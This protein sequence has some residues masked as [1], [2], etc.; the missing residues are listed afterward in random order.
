MCLK[1]PKRIGGWEGP[2][3]WIDER[4]A[5]GQARPSK[6]V[7]VNKKSGGMI[8]LQIAPFR[9][10][11]RI[12]ILNVRL[13]LGYKLPLSPAVEVI[14]LFLWNVQLSTDIRPKMTTHLLRTTSPTPSNRSG[15][16]TLTSRISALGAK[17]TR[18]LSGGDR[19]REEEVHVPV[20]IGLVRFGSVSLRLFNGEGV[21]EKTRRGG[22]EGRE[23][24][25]K[26]SPLRVRGTYLLSWRDKGLS[27]IDPARASAFSLLISGQSACS[28]L[29]PLSSLIS[30]YLFLSAL[31]CVGTAPLPPPPLPWVPPPTES[32]PCPPNLANPT[33]CLESGPPRAEPRAPRVTMDI[34]YGIIQAF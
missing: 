12:R 7:Q 14:R 11:I 9:I 17:L 32:Q 23:K 4:Q 31:F 34:N 30:S 15:T 3:L 27:D 5:G 8:A 26:I 2:G 25:G 29:P 22:K 16:P 24:E 6:Q 13:V 33:P 28:L 1:N 19:V 21:H 18:T 10:Q 20:F